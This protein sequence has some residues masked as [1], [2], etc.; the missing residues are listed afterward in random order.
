VG[1][2]Q[3]GGHLDPNLERDDMLDLAT[4][5]TQKEHEYA[6]LTQAH[7]ELQRRLQEVTTALLQA[8]GAVQ[9]LRSLAP[10]PT[11]EANHAPSLV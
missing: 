9:V 7:A 11:P 6:Q 2:H 8:Q 4:L 10:E 3:Y 5:L 1:G